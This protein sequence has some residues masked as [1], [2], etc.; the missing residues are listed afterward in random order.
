MNEWRRTVKTGKRDA[1]EAPII[2][3]LE[4]CGWFVWQLSDKDWPD[5]FIARAGRKELVEVKDKNQ[6]QSEGQKRLARE[7]LAF[8]VHVYVAYTPEQL[9]E[10]LEIYP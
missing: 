2:Q 10:D 6:E 9:I 5:L 7:L 3:A 4:K 8:S 1:N